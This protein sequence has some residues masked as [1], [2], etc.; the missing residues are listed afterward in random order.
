[1]VLS[2]TH[3]HSYKNELF[4]SDYLESTSTL[5][6]SLVAKEKIISDLNAEVRKLENTLSEE[7]DQ[8]MDEIKMFNALLEEKV[9]KPIYSMSLIYY[10]SL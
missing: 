4:Y 5:E 6:S 7:R 9:N 3:T 8:H 2:F 10:P 1:M